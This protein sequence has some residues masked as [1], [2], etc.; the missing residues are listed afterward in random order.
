MGRGTRVVQ[1]HAL[2]RDKPGRGGKM[3]GVWT[4]VVQNH[5]LYRDK[6]GRGGR[7]VGLRID[8]LPSE[9]CDAI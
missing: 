2:Y 9:Y 6:P 4:R 1:N 5:A 3:D 8:A 7:T